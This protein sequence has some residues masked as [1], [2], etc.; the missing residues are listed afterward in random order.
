[1]VAGGGKVILQLPFNV[2]QQCKRQGEGW[3][4]EQHFKKVLFKQKT[5]SSD[6]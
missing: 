5:N 2:G 1:M 6:I 3:T 4:R